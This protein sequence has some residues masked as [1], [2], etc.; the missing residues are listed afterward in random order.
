MLNVLLRA[1]RALLL[2]AAV[3]RTSG[4]VASAE[5][6]RVPL[7]TTIP[8]PVLAGTP[9]EV[10]LKLFP[11][12]AP[13]EELP[14]LLVPAGTTNL[15]LHRPV[16]SSDQTPVIGELRFVTDG[17][18]SGVSGTEVELGPLAQWVQ[19]DLG[20]PSTIYAVHIW[21]FFREA[22]SYHDVVVQ[23]AEDEECT[24]DVHT[25][26]NSDRKDALRLGAGKDRPYIET[27]SGKLIDAQGVTGRYVRLYSR[28]STTDDLNHYVEVEVFGK[29]VP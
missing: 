14:R 4:A 16:T 10:L 15:A 22:R 19:I 17:E 23:I 28:G 20:Q 1:L 27:N 29:P 2:V 8:R 25:I 13:L 5:E 26:F 7:E 21:H 11:H 9:P 24:R 6:N 3:V 18:K 12:L